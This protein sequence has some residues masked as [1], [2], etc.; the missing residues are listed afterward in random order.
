MYRLKT[1]SALL[2]FVFATGQLLMALNPSREYKSKP[3]KFNMKYEESKVKTLDGNATVN[4][5]YF[6]C[7]NKTTPLTVIISHNGEGNMGKYLRRVDQF[8]SIGYNVVT[9]DYRGF[10]ESSE[11]E[12][13][14]G[15]YLY[16]H[17]Q[18]DLLSVM[19]FVRK[20]YVNTFA[21][22]GWGIGAGMSLGIGYNRGEVTKVIADTPFFSMEDLEERFEDSD[23]PL[24]VPFAGYD[25]KYEPF[26][27]FDNAF[28]GKIK[29]VLLIVGTN[30]DLYK[31]ADME[32]LRKKQ[33]K[34]TQL[35]VVEN[36]E[37]KD[38]F[39]VDR[40][41]YFEAMRAFLEGEKK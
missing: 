37:N 41:A 4:V 17:F 39:K 24:E 22:Y 7:P 27:A 35:Y 31:P 11:F 2:V 9:Y 26:Y 6:P 40:S 32:A 16:P 10:G 12:I 1:L 30:D 14:N 29:S 8:T 38:N 5:W 3:D 20:E 21:L 19:D 34:I 15:M 13:D 18:N 25:K 33:K 23:E 36:P 28:V